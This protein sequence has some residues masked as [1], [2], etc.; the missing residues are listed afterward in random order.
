[1]LTNNNSDDN[2]LGC[3][4]VSI[5]TTLVLIPKAKSVHVDDVQ[6]TP[7]EKNDDDLAFLVGYAC[8]T[9]L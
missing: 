2:A 1:M 7:E 5:P 6:E 3:V 4:Q 8:A 9:R